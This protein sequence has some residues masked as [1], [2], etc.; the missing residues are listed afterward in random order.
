MWF[1][2]TM[3]LFNDYNKP[4]HVRANAKI[5]LEIAIDFDYFNYLIIYFAVCILLNIKK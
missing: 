1:R 2:V 3:I 5:W 4:D